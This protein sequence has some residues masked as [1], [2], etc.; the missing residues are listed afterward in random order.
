[1]LGMVCIDVDGTLVGTDNS[2]RADVWDALAALHAEG[3]HLVLCSGRPAFGAARGYAERLEPSGWHV[4][5]NGAS[6]VQVA[7]QKSLSESFPAEQLTRLLQQA[8]ANGRTLEIYTD[9]E[10]ASTTQ[11]P[12]DQAHAEL[13][14]LPYQPRTPEELQGK[15]VRAQWLVPYAEYPKLQAEMVPELDYHPAGSPRM[16]DVLFMSM[17]RRGVSKGSAIRRIAQEYGVPLE[18]TMMVGDGENDLSAMSVVGHKVAMGNADTALL[19]A[20]EH[21]VS[22]VDAG[23]LLEALELA[24][25]L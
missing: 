18:R 19:N 7:E 8:H 22:H 10:Y 23:G 9:T 24:R 6:V 14:G 5:Q 20:A 16:T 13:L 1:M 4:F 3:V 21:K 25:T 12:L 11:G 15:V 2:V 17:T